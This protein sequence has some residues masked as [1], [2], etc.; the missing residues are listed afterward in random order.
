MLERICIE[1]KE[2]QFKLHTNQT[3]LHSDKL[4]HDTVYLK[5]TATL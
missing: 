4:V 2:N 1:F 5:V 3:E